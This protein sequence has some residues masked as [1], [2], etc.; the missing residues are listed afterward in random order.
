MKDAATMQRRSDDASFL[1]YAIAKKIF[2]LSRLINLGLYF[3]RV[4]SALQDIRRSLRYVRL[5]YPQHIDRVCT[6]YRVTRKHFNEK[7]AK[8][9][10]LSRDTET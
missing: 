2:R 9:R 6:Y 1:T 4:S 7:N 10:Q 3:E 5:S 8:Q